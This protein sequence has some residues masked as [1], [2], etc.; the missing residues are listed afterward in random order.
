MFDAKRFPS[1]IKLDSKTFPRLTEVTISFWLRIWPKL[2]PTEHTILHYRTGSYDGLCLFELTDRHHGF[3]LDDADTVLLV[4]LTSNL[5][6]NVK[7]WNRIY[8]VSVP[9]ASDQWHHVTIAHHLSRRDEIKIMLNS[10]LVLVL[11]S[12]NRQH[13]DRRDQ[14]IAIDSGGELFVGQ[15]A[16]PRNTTGTSMTGDLEFDMQRAF[17]G[18]ITFLNIWQKMMADN[19][20]HQLAMDCHVQRQE[21]GDAVTWMDFV[22]DIKGETQ[23][24]W[25]SGIY[26]LFGRLSV[27]RRN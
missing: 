22:N 6:L 7:V 15:A 8:D 24:H 19:E 17:H 14:F 12:S 26:T 16:R 20:M 9:L 25:P 10:S 2:E 27:E 18:E 5:R 21:C 23:I 11:I 4:S 3:V 1:Y 13:S